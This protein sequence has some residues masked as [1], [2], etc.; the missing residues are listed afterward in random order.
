MP[1]TI[2]AVARLLLTNGACLLSAK[3]RQRLHTPHYSPLARRT[4]PADYLLHSIELSRSYLTVSKDL[5]RLMNRLKGLYRSWAIPCA[6]Q[7]VYSPRQRAAWL[8]KLGEAGVVRRAGRLYE[9]LDFLLRLRKETSTEMLSE[10]RKHPAS[11]LLQQIPRLGPIRVA[12]MIAD[13][14]FSG[15]DDRGSACRQDSLLTTPAVIF[16]FPLCL[17]WCRRHLQR[18]LPPRPCLHLASERRPRRPH[19]PDSRCCISGRGSCRSGKRP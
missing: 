15:I 11:K 3:M 4:S 18:Q 6:G 10:S 5:T 2:P 19:C 1:R 13:F 8:E 7:Q 17:S 12:L 16:S 14:G 9:Q